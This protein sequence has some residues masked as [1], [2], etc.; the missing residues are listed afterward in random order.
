MTT[1]IIETPK[2]GFQSIVQY[3]QQPVYFFRFDVEETENDTIKCKEVTIALD[4]ATYDKMVA[5]CIEVKY[6]IDAQ[7]ALLYNYQL[8][9]Q[10]YQQKMEDYQEW[11]VYCKDACREFFGNE[12][13]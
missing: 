9:V 3:G 7:L 2:A 5:V 8:D 10:A 1:T 13:L 11:R 12:E 6:S 4:N